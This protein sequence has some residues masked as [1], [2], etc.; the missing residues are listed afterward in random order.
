MTESLRQADAFEITD[1]MLNAATQ[2]LNL[3]IGDV[4]DREAC[5]ASRIVE[6][7]VVAFLRAST[8]IC[9]DLLYAGKLLPG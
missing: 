7:V 8:E 2:A 1:A 4:L 3:E 5:D 9:Q 6:S